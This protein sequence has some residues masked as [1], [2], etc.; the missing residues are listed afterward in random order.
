MEA[1]TTAFSIRHVDEALIATWRG[2]LQ[3]VA[4]DEVIRLGDEGAQ[5]LDVREA[6]EFAKGHLVGSI[7]IGLGGGSVNIGAFLGT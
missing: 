5:V 2:V 1:L 3:P 4:L 6:A 7:N